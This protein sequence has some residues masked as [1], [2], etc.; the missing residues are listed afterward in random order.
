M[1]AIR[2]QYD[3]DAAAGTP[4]SEDQVQ[5][6]IEQA[7]RE[8]DGSPDRFFA[9]LRELGGGFEQWQD[10]R[11]DAALQAELDRLAIG[12]VSRTPL[13]LQH[14]YALLQRGMPETQPAAVHDLPSPP[15]RDLPLLLAS[16]RAQDALLL[17]SVA[18]NT[19]SKPDIADTI[20]GLHATWSARFEAAQT[21]QARVEAVYALQAA[22]RGLL[23]EP[24]YLPYL[25][26]LQ[27]NLRDFVSACASDEREAYA[28]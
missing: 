2:L 16:M 27:R 24:R 19:V 17:L 5:K 7:A 6:Q 11:G 26:D 8:I 18:A 1:Q 10:G 15:E 3:P 12:E 4:G 25:R 9:M 23:G 20:N 22:L 28:G 21:Y 14:G 13:R